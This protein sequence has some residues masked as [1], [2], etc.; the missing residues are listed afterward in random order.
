MYQYRAKILRVVDGD[1]VDVEVDLGFHIKVEMKLRLYGIN[2]PELKEDAGKVSRDK[3]KEM[4][5]GKVVTVYTIKDRQE[6]YGRYLA[7]IVLDDN[8]EINN[9]LVE[10][11]LAVRYMV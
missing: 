5:D 2:A 7:K 11:G 6:K 3:L 4:L 10:Q 9:W 1:T 8:T